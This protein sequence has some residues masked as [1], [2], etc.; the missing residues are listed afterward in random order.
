MVRGAD[1]I[2]LI[3]DKG[4]YDSTFMITGA[5]PDAGPQ[6]TYYAGL[7]AIILLYD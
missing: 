3:L 6:R 7:S 1:S 2:K 4:Y 5:K